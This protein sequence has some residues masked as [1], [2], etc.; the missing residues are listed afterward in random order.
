V[1]ILLDFNFSLLRSNLA[2][3]GK[4]ME[5]FDF[6]LIDS[7]LQLNSVFLRLIANFNL[8]L[9]DSRIQLESLILKLIETNFKLIY[10]IL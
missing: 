1:A 9:I 7:N 8:K 5:Y 2:I 10:S 3:S 6:K 4:W